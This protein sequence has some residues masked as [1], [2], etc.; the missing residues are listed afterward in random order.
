[1]KWSITSAPYFSRR[2]RSAMAIPT[3]LPKPWPSGP[4]VTSTPGVT[5]TRSRSGWPGVSEPHWRKRLI[6]SSGRAYPEG[7]VGA[8]GGHRPV[9]QPRAVAR[10]EHE[11][12]AV[13]PLR[14]A[15]V[16]LH[17]PLEEQVRRRRHCHRHAGVARVR[18]LDG[19]HGERA[20]RVDAEAFDVL[21]HGGVLS[22]IPM[23]ENFHCL[24]EI[25]KGSRNK[26]EWDPELNA[27]KLDRF[28]FSSVVYPT[29]YG[30]I[31]E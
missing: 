7:R 21:G 4:V 31:P 26:Y 10:R 29:D 2:K 30:F 18:R 13:G 12:V 24:V 16:V 5:C 22:R 28:L 20:D 11:P 3:P 23:A 15:R 6:S 14:I 17:D 8:R 1:M 19:V 9:E 27:I 25:P